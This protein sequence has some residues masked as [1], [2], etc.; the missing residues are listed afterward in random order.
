MGIVHQELVD[1]KE[2]DC[3]QRA[4][5]TYRRTMGSTH[6]T[7]YLLA[8][9]L[10]TWTRV[11]NRPDLKHSDLFL[12]SSEL[13]FEQNVLEY[14]SPYPQGM[15]IYSTL[16]QLT[17]TVYCPEGATNV[18]VPQE[19]GGS[20]ILC[21]MRRFSC[22]VPSSSPPKLRLYGKYARQKTLE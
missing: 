4:K 18:T 10:R 21:L 6:G 2:V 9:L 22:T 17:S 13:Y 8:Y 5:H 11:T 16:I 14:I 7:K 3:W 15:T 12:L 19:L 1:R 20:M